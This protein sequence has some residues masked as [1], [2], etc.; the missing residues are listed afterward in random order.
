MLIRW[1]ATAVATLGVG[2][3]PKAPGTWGS[4]L[5]VLV[6][7]AIMPVNLTIQLVSIV[8]AFI[9]GWVAT[10][11]YEKFY[12]KHDPK[13]VVI[14]ELVGMWMV[15]VVFTLSSLPSW[16]D[17]A[18]GFLLFRLFDIWKP[19]PVGWIDRR[20]PGAFGTMIDDVAAAVMAILL[21][22]ALGWFGIY[23]VGVV[24]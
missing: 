1:L 16:M 4:L 9:M 17:V 24:F 6:W 14:D 11:Y 8:V 12:D 3:I 10:R 7:K 21:L 2:K 20:V 18:L 23:S 19:F 5:A 13:E 15:M 22:L